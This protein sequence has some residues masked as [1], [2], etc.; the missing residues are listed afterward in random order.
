V[1]GLDRPVQ[2]VASHDGSGFLY[3]AQQPGPILRVDRDGVTAPFLDLTSIISCCDN[4]GV[5]SVVFH[6]SYASNGKLY[7]LY[8]DRN[9]NTALARYLRST[10]DP[11]VADPKSAEILF[12]VEQPKDEVPNHHGGTLQFGPDGMLYVSIGDGGALRK[13]TNRAQEFSHLLGK[14]LRI[15]VD[16][17]TPYAIPPDNPY[18]GVA[19]VRP[20]IWSIGFRNPW[21]FSFDRA[22]GELLI[23]DVGQDLWEEIDAVSI[24][25]ARGANFGWPMLEGSHCF[26]RDA[27]CTS[28]GTVLPK[29]EYS[30][31]LGCSVSGG[32]RYRGGRWPA[33][34]GVY[35][36]GDWCSGRL[37][38]A[39]E[40]TDG[41]WTVSELA[42]LPMAIVSFG[43]DDE[44]ELY[45]VDW[46]GNVFRLI[47]E[48]TLRRR[49][50][51][52]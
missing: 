16:R 22:T 35:F 7:V 28:A 12:V 52:R 49:A 32:Y 40:N 37:W 2:I 29:A 23:G 26:P 45:L 51:A 14:L 6:P 39:T 25:A 46:L 11:T 43:E 41:S 5:L 38:G 36:Y 48:G 33:L 50:V 18:A 34:R 1:R 47:D 13:V 4:G 24:A 19:G 8:V 30:H 17:G 9:G 3:V 15:D 10:F 31:E 20:E 27:V 44:G 42:K 21:R